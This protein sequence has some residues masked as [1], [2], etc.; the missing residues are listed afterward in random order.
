MLFILDF[1]YLAVGRIFLQEKTSRYFCFI[2]LFRDTFDCFCRADLSYLPNKCWLSSFCWSNCQS[3][4]GEVLEAPSRTPATTSYSSFCNIRKTIIF[5]EE[6][7]PFGNWIAVPVVIP[8]YLSAWTPAS[9]ELPSA[10]AVPSSIAD[11]NLQ[12]SLLSFDWVVDSGSSAFLLLSFNDST[13]LRVAVPAL[14]FTVNRWVGIFRWLLAASSRIQS[15]I[16]WSISLIVIFSFVVVGFV[17]FLFKQEIR[18]SIQ[19]SDCNL[20]F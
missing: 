17:P 13:F 10:L 1:C 7:T 14:I 12:P 3:R 19:S 9:A 5:S 15:P 2:L 20:N 4:S 18:F 6:S 8:L 11:L 16:C